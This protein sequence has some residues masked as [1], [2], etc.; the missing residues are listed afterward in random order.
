MLPHVHNEFEGGLM[1]AIHRF[2]DFGFEFGAFIDHLHILFQPV[3]IEI[4][5]NVL[6]I[7]LPLVDTENHHI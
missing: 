1:M 3:R 6:L 5:P 2:L 7:D 4:L